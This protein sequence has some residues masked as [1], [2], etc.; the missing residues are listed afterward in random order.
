ML[1]RLAVAAAALVVAFAVYRLWKR[2]PRR[3]SGASLVELGVAGPAIV[4]FSTRSCAPCRAAWPR[5]IEAA[6][7]AEVDY[8]QIELDD[9]PEVAGRF[10]IRSVPTI[11]VTG[12]GGAV[13]GV[14]TSLPTNGEIAEAAR[15]AK[16][17]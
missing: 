14:W 3:L 9:R 11:V 13:Q 1:V 2:P 15:R 17:A 16:P 12:P 7:D 5:L 8:A 4:Q 6:A 10:G